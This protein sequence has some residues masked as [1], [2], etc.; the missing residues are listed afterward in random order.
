MAEALLR[1]RAGGRFNAYSAGLVHKDELFPPVIQAMAEVGLD[2]SGQR[3]KSVSQYLG[4]MDFYKVVAVC[5]ETEKSCPRIFGV[6]NMRWLSWPFD[7]PAAVVGTEEEI[8]T[9][10]RRVRDEIDRRI[11]DWLEEEGVPIQPLA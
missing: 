6:L 10:T 8:L 1:A 7:D 9:V 2:V 5:A 11:C 4:K 3:P